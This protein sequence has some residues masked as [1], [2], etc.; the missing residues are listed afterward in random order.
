MVVSPPAR[1]PRS[2]WA[3]ACPGCPPAVALLA[4]ATLALVLLA[5]PILADPRPPEV[6]DAAQIRLALEKLNV[7]GSVLYV[8]AHPDDE[9]TAFLAWL[10]NGRK[11]RTAYLAATRACPARGP[12]CAAAASGIG[13]APAR[14]GAAC[15]RCA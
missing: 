8:G 6:Q 2:P 15:R 11:V 1:G 3:V 9:N 14:A 4:V 12:R 13:G 5:R 10:A 7:V